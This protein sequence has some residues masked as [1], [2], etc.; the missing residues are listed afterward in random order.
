MRPALHRAGLF[1]LAAFAFSWTIFFA[2]ELW[3]I[4]SFIDPTDSAALGLTQLASHL[5]GMMGPALAAFGLWRAFKEPAQPAWRWGHSKF[6]VWSAAFLILLRS[7]ALAVGMLDAPNALQLRTA[8]EPYLW[9][10]LGASLTIGWLAGMGEEIGWCAY[11]LPLLEPALGKF[12]AT[13][14][15]G[16]L[17]GVWHL[18][19]L[20][21]PLLTQVW[22][23]EITWEIFLVNTLMLGGVLL[24]SNILFGAV[25]SGL[26]F[27]TTS[28]ALLGW[29]HQWY[30]LTRDAA[31]L[32]TS[33]LAGS[34]ATALTYNIGIYLLGLVALLWLARNSRTRQFNH[35]G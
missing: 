30:D 33:E 11:L 6:F 27:K 20:A 15:A 3:F 13:V 21:L 18:P 17:R 24:F 34:S 9:L 28:M 1:A 8:L 14:L 22:K 16:A 4:P 31:A 32:F 29:T 25:M 19:V 7:A 23:A 10:V 5:L 12:G 26:W 2:A 35:A